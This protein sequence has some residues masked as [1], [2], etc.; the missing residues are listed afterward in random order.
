VLAADDRRRLLANLRLAAEN[1]KAP[2][3]RV[4]QVRRQVA[5]LASFDRAPATAGWLAELRA[6]VSR[7]DPGSRFS[8]GWAEA[9]SV[10]VA[11][12]RQG[13]PEALGRFVEVGRTDDSWKTANLNYWAYWAGDTRGIERDDTFI[14]AGLGRWRGLT[15]LDH[16]TARLGPAADD[17][18]LNVHTVW[19]LLTRRRNLLDDDPELAAALGGRVTVLLDSA[20]LAPAIRGDAESIRAALTMAGVR[21]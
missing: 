12:G 20:Q 1:P 7:N 21:T 9:R 13:N 8:A 3:D 15:L 14:G 5:Y 4:S 10:A 11:L 2:A 18:S 17:L 6:A 19:A 16:L